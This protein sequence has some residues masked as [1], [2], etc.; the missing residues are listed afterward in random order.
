MPRILISGYYGFGNAGDE[1]ILQAIVE[2]LRRVEA[3]V[4]ISVL[5]AD[6]EG[7]RKL[8][9]EP[10]PR[11][12]PGP[13]LRALRACNL[14]LSGGG[15][16]IQDSTG[17]N[18]VIYYLGVCL[19]ARLVRRPVML[20]CQGFGPVKTGLGRQLTR[21]ANG[22]QLLTW[23]DQ[24]SADE[25]RALGVA[26]PPSRV[27]AD[28][29]LGL[30][31]CQPARVNE[32]LTR[33]GLTADVARLERPAGPGSAEVGPLVGV[34]V[35]H[36]PGLD[37]EALAEGLRRF[38]EEDKARLLLLPFQPSRDRPLSEEL[39]SRLSP[40]ARLLRAD[41]EPKELMGLLSCLDLVLGM[42]LH[43][44]IM[45]AARG[46]PFLGLAYD[47]KVERFCQRC[48]AMSLSLE[49][50]SAEGLHKALFHLLRARAPMRQELQ[51]RIP[52]MVACLRGA[53]Q[54]ALALARGHDSR[55]ALACFEANPA[56]HA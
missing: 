35:R 46:I 28:P 14:L 22:L 41:Y 23:R 17:V 2:D 1:A 29:V 47:P 7:A 56:L 3:E 15:G 30:E 49:G 21:L 53:A 50:L 5:T 27:T 54:A 19:L 42:R 8:G 31:P 10:V 25:I 48:G 16:L 37:R 36:W 40:H 12:A 34:A 11:N 32:I 39:C 13:V 52:P 26:R 20:Y 33:E 38:A 51:R 6:P 18:S 43:A 9:L 44:A 55:A 24:E 4:R 45:A